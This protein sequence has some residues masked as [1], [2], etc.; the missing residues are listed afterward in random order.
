MSMPTVLV[1][2]GTQVTTSDLHLF[3]HRAFAGIGCRSVFVSNDSHL[4]FAE[5]VL[6]QA[7]LR[8]SSAHFAAFNWRMR[9]VAAKV[10][11]DLVFITGSNWYV[12]PE[13]IRLFQRRY[14]ARVV[15]NEQHLQVFRPYQAECL[16]LYD[17]VFTQDSGLVSLL[18]HASPARAVSL[19]GP[20]CDPAEHRPLPLSPTDQ[21]AYG[22]DVAYLGYAYPNRLALFEALLGLRLRVWGV[23]WER[24]EALRP[25]YDPRPIH[26]L[27]KMKV[28]NAT[29]VNVNMQSVQ[30]QMDGVTCRPFEVL[31]C[32][33]FC[34]ADERRDLGR[35]F[36]VGEEIV[37]YADAADLRAK[38]EH[39]LAHEDEARAIAERG[40]RRVLAEHT[41][42]HRARQVLQAVKLA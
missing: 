33:A 42:Q 11:P 18:A 34:L 32:G 27:R 6:Q 28:Y 39:Y 16:G 25:H 26:G 22:A 23:G 41:Y 35:F 3:F 21:A 37:S 13:T 29:R 5:K 24:S 30:Y 14:G 20:A 8:F 17:H 36:R 4:P 7:R 10:R 15:L 31:A 1:I 12:M 40:R 9:Q 2:G 19:L 38:V